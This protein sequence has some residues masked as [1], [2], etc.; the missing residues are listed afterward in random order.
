MKIFGIKRVTR[1]Y[2]ELTV[3]LQTHEYKR[4]FH[5]V[6]TG[7]IT[8]FGLPLLPFKTIVVPV[9]KDDLIKLMMV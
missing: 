5:I 2:Y 3:N 4:N 9:S 7:Y 8:V 6:K 1:F